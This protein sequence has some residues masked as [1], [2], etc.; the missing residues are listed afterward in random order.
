MLTVV[1]LRIVKVFFFLVHFPD[2]I[3]ELV[4]FIYCCITNHSKLSGFRPGSHLF[5]LYIF[6]LGKAHLAGTAC[7]LTRGVRWGCWRKGGSSFPGSYNRLKAC[8]LLCLIVNAG[9]WQ[10]PGLQARTPIYDLFMTFWFPHSM[11]AGFQERASQKSKVK[12]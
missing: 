8:S 12:L 10:G 7:L 2:C 4:L 1:K 5:C 3:Y 9:C 6:N 11:L